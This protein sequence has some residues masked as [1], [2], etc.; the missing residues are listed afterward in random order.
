MNLR[1][2][3]FRLRR[4]AVIVQLAFLAG[5]AY[6]ANLR[7]ETAEQPTVGKDPQGRPALLVKDA[8]AATPEEMK[9][10]TEVITGRDVTF[11]MVPIPGGKFK[12]GSPDD[13]EGRN[14]DEGPVHEVEI[15]PFW[16]GKHETTW[17]EFETFSF[18]LDI[19][20]RQLAK[21]EPNELEVKA[22]VVMRPTKP[23]TDMTFG[24]GQHGFPVIC[25]TE[26]AAKKYCEWLTAKTGRYYRLPTEAEWE[27]ACRAG[28]DT[29]YSFG[30]DPEELENY[31]WFYDNSDE[32]YHK[33]G[34]KKPNP[35][36]LH[37]MHGNVAEFVLD[38]YDA[39]RY[40]KYANTLTKN[41][42]DPP[43]ALY[44]RVARGGSWNDD[45]EKLRSAARL[46][47]HKDWKR[48]DPQLPQSMW[49]YTDA[50]WVGFRVVRPFRD[51]TDE[52]KKMYGPDKL[53]QYK[54]K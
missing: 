33:V 41:H 46:E 31:A 15:E 29:P 43:H 37:D 30:D 38:G 12:M 16:M 27:Y 26:L 35:W 42:F 53:Q 50:Q 14:A 52:E 5:M 25:M 44:S 20:G 51:P 19:Q 8:Y 48:Q 7:A 28:T 36:G 23:Y 9:P 17:D 4:M 54:E 1:L 24:M 3:S 2:T 45:P 47:S 18:T 13:E 39:K 10:Y 32:A 6:S 22:D 11:D 40:E 49:Y 21:S 34:K